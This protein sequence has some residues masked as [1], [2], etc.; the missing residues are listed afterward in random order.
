MGSLKDLRERAAE[1]ERL[2]DEATNPDAREI[3]LLV[4]GR[5]QWLADEDE[6]KAAREA[7]TTDDGRPS[8]I[9]R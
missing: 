2:A 4:A 1:Y 7:L 5:W 6:A 8:E 9:P 3:M